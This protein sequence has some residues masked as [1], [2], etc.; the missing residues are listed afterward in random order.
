MRT[1]FFILILC[2][3]TGIAAQPGLYAS[4]QNIE[5]PYWNL[6]NPSGPSF[7]QHGF[8]AGVHYQ[9]PFSKVS[10]VFIPGLNYSFFQKRISESGHNQAH[11]LQ[12]RAALRVFPIE[13]FLNCDCPSLKKGLFFE[14]F[15]GWSRW[16]FMHQEFDIH[17]EGKSNAALTGL[18][19]GFTL[20]YGKHLT[21]APLF[22][23]TFY[24]SITWEGLSAIRNPDTD[25]F[26]REET[27]LRQM[28][29]EIHILFN[30]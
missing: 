9:I 3:S 19:A 22:R 11:M 16:D 5:A 29:F 8:G 26:F 17:L 24:P 6:L 10:F 13:F 12:L 25:P 23:Y 30:R 4:Y 18:G 2:L 21:V 20:S 7:I 28:S 27:F 15:T 1:A 14:G